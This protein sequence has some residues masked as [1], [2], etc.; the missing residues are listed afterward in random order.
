MTS[1]SSA[2]LERGLDTMLLVYAALQGH[3]AST[4]CE[5][6]IRGHSGWLTS[7]LILLEA[8]SVLTKVYSVAAPDATQKLALF[9]TMPIAVIDLDAGIAAAALQLADAYDL[10]IADAVLLQMTRNH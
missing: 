3:P 8:K 7:P 9:A 10:D 2:T 5:Q 6:F 4:I 1:S